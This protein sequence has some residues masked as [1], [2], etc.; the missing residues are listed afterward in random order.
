MKIILLNKY[1]RCIIILIFLT[2][3]LYSC[4]NN[5]SEA[6]QH[7]LQFEETSHKI[8]S[9]SQTKEFLK[10]QIILKGHSLLLNINTETESSILTAN[11][12]DIIT[13]FNFTYDTDLD[14][15]L[16]NIKVLNSNA[17]NDI[18]VVLP[19]ATEEFLTFQLIKFETK[20]KVFKEGMFIIETHE[21]NNI[22]NFY[23]NHKIKLTQVKDSFEIL[24]GDY[25]YKGEF[26]EF[27]I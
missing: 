18:I 7:S 20:Q 26:S 19:E 4:K 13:D 24:L 27:K 14:S 17:N 1:L 25:K 12:K 9:V 2:H 22:R 3:V 21:Y 16:K 10:F 23:L 5:H 11:D 15:A 8:E 6:N